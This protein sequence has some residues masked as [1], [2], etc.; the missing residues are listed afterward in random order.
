[1]T[2]HAGQ[3]HIL[4][5][6]S[7]V[8]GL[9]VFDEVRARLPNACVSYAMDH[10]AF[11]YGTKSEAW[12]T[13]HVP[14]LLTGIADALSP[15]ILVV[16]CN[17]ASTIALPEIRARL[18]IPVVGTVPAIK[19]A[20]ETSA[21]GTIGLLATPGTVERYYTQDLIEQFAPTSRVLRHGSSRLVEIAEAKACHQTIK[22]EEIAAELAPLFDQDNN[23]TMDT[24]VLACTHFPLLIEDLR[25]ASPRD[26]IWIDSG[27]AIAART[28]EIAQN[29]SPAN[30]KKAIARSFSTAVSEENL[31]PYQP[32]FKLRGFGEIGP[33]KN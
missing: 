32:A 5:F 27:S 33:L 13:K 11:P 1:M 19:P 16:A 18:S 15:D 23:E 26:V 29:L 6:D 9:T 22:R 31:S 14:D 2:S 4:I 25:A 21:S 30:R 10:A 12:L 17:T 8:G 28:E 3:P 24:I 7:G 20:A